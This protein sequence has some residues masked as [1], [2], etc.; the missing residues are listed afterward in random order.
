[1]TRLPPVLAPV[2]LALA[3]TA[4]AQQQPA[5]DGGARALGME[6]AVQ[7]KWLDAYKQL[8]PWALAHPDDVQARMVA[9]YSAVRLARLAEAER[10]LS[11]LPQ[12]EPWVRLL[13]GD[14]LL[15]QGNPWG[16]L[17]ML[18]P[19]EKSHP[20][21]LERDLRRLLDLARTQASGP[22]PPAPV[23]PV[24]RALV[25]AAELAVSGQAEEGLR[26]VRDELLLSPDDL[27][28]RFME[29]Y[30]LLRLQRA[31]EAP[32]PSW[33]SAARPNRSATCG[34]PSLSSPT[35]WAR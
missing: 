5:S 7:G 23:D 31:E 19:L 16:T 12:N 1:M 35:I 2:L 28:P 26:R 14:L 25:Q 18:K 33:P 3:L 13:W 15:A 29:G 32:P 34:R 8:K 4:G 30:L 10:L 24:E 17:D 20:P 11:D 9:A 27:R 21:E 22:P 6:L